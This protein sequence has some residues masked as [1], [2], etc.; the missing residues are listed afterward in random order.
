MN[1]RVNQLRNMRHR[2]D[3]F[4]VIVRQVPLCVEHKS[5]HCSV[6]HFFSTHHPHSYYSCRIIYDGKEFEDLT[7][8]L[9]TNSMFVRL[10]VFLQL[11]PFI[12]NLAK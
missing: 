8:S 7:V 6:D 9:G 11:L 3:Q 4:S 5:R 10:I 12:Y 2:P 1:K